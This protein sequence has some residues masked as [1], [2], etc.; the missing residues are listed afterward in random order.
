MPHVWSWNRTNCSTG[1]NQVS[2]L[3]NIE[4]S[5]S[6]AFYRQNQ[7]KSTTWR[8]FIRCMFDIFRNNRSPF[9]HPSN[10]ADGADGWYL[11]RETSQARHNTRLWQ[12]AGFGCETRCS[13]EPVSFREKFY[14]A[15]THTHTQRDVLRFDLS[16]AFLLYHHHSQ[17]TTELDILVQVDRQCTIHVSC[18]N[19]HFEITL[20]LYLWP[21]AH[22]KLDLLGQNG[23]KDDAR[24]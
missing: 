9:V 20:F 17:S 22:S 1:Q 24:L 12:G 7:F 3:W 14:R 2:T 15:S 13:M 18:N 11:R 6:N 8:R 19:Q 5:I 21:C 23:R 16:L 10:Q 4:N